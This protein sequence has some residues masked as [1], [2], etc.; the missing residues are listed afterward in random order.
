MPQT[1]R[2]S[3][4]INTDG[5]SVSNVDL[6]QEYQHLIDTFGWDKGHLL[7]CNL[8]AIEHAFTTDT[9]KEKVRQQ[10]LR[11]YQEG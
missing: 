4:S 7:A 2:S 9:V 10:L 6:Q 3:L 1:T 11:G 8:A 5:R